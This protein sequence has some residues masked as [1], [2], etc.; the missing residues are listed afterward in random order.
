M[1]GS[2]YTSWKFK[3]YLLAKL[4]MGFLAGLK[5]DS[6]DE[7]KCQVSVPY[8]WLNQNPFNSMYFAVQSMAAE[9]STALPCLSE[10]QKSK[11]SIAFIIVENKA[12][13]TKKAASRVQ[14]SCS[15]VTLAAEA[16]KKA[17]E[18]GEPLTQTFKTVGV[19]SNGDIVSEFH[20]TW[21][22]K[23]RSS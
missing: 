14:F 7:E 8:K 22:F 18:T 19:Q 5:V 23:L 1:S 11:K 21:S 17:V 9:L 2:N 6:L 12:I 16:V 13:F 15:G 20:F 4:P 10:I 3:F